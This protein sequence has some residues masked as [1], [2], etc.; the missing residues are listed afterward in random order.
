MRRA[1]NASL[2]D[3]LA[4]QWRQS[5]QGG[6]ALRRVLAACDWAAL[7]SLLRAL[8]DGI[9]HDW[10]RRNEIANYEGY[11]ASV[12]YAFFQA[13]L[14]GVS[15]EDATSRGRLDLVVQMGRHAYLFEFKMTQRVGRGGA[16]AQMKTRRSDKYR[17]PDR[18]VHLIRVEINAESRNL[19]A[20]EIEPA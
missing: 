16:L 19:A 18:L 8:L 14:D 11:W 6:A 1:L 5:A 10:H 13:S 15:V 20:F 9:P 3:A 7:E 4:P 12:F 17:A 2:L